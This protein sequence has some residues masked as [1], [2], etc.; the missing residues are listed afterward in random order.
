M[1]K[2]WVYEKLPW[3]SNSYFESWFVDVDGAT[4]FGGDLS[5]QFHFP[6]GIFLGDS[7]EDIKEK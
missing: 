2:E 7:A 4:Y 6:F 3:Y 1:E 5:Y